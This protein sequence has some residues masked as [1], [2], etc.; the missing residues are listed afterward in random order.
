MDALLSVDN[1]VFRSL[2]LYGSITILKTLC[3]AP[4]TGITKRRNDAGHQNKEDALF[5][6]KGDESK[7]KM[8]MKKDDDVER[9]KENFNI[10]SWLLRTSHIR[11]Y[12]ATNCTQLFFSIKLF[13]F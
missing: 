10:N 7:V 3:L 6:A 8:F 12:A 11:S 4:L 13:I 2:L 5:Y 1:E 9:V